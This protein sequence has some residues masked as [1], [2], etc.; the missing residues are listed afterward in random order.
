MSVGF[1]IFQRGGTMARLAAADMPDWTD[2]AGGKEKWAAWAERKI[3][4]LRRRARTWKEKRR[5]TSPVA[6]E[7]EW[8]DAL[9][10]AIKDSDGRGRYS[11]LPLSLTHEKGNTAAMWPSVEHLDDPATP[12]LALETRLV[13]DMKTIMSED[14]LKEM[15]GHLAAVQRIQ[16]REVADSWE[17]GRSFAVEQP[18]DDEPPLPDA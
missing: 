1:G 4:P 17:P 15:V 6:G 10:K 2:G 8:R 16:P 3:A 14:E 5:D 12:N 9:L 18:S 7:P 11:R 13:N